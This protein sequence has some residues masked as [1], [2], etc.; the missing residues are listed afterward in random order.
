MFDARY[1]GRRI[2]VQLNPVDLPKGVRGVWPGTG[3][4]EA[5]VLRG[6][7]GNLFR[8]HLDAPARTRQGIDVHDVVV[9]GIDMDLISE[10]FE[11]SRRPRGLPVL[12]AV[13]RLSENFS[14]SGITSGERA[15]GRQNFLGRATLVLVT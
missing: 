4:I 13:W 9:L 8:V 11:T 12:G 3:T 6:T 1:V 15:L 14:F 2:S 7:E 10:L 5:V